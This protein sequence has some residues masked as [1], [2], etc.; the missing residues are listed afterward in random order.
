[1]SAPTFPIPV[2]VTIRRGSDGVA[3]VSDE[4]WTLQENIDE[5]GA[6]LLFWWTEGNG[7]CD[8][9]RRLFF[10]RA[11]GEPDPEDYDCTDGE[12]RITITGRDGRVWYTDDEAP[13][14]GE[15]AAVATAPA[16]APR[17]PWCQP[18][19]SFHATDAATRAALRCFAEAA[20]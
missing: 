15:V 13:A 11:A 2:V 12:Y 17:A 1:M 14:A 3:R 8:C 5:P 9:N 19:Q 10:A 20:P 16:A 18:C 4:N 6:P 7:G